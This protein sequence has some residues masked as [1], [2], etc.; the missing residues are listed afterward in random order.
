MSVRY[1]DVGEVEFI[2]KALEYYKT[3]ISDKIMKTN[4]KKLIKGF[5]IGDQIF[6]EKKYFD[7]FASKDKE[8]V[9]KALSAYC[10]QRPPHSE[11]GMEIL[12]YLT[13]TKDQK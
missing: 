13:Q 1:L 5:R 4:I 9:E 2:N 3:R 7:T 6:F 11:V 8:L 12:S 10:K